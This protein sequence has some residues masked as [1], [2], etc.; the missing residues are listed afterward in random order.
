M[1]KSFW[2]VIGSIFASFANRIFFGAGCHLCRHVVLVVV[3]ITITSV[4]AVVV[5]GVQLIGIVPKLLLELFLSET[6]KAP[7][8]NFFGKIL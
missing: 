4:I 7:K 3:A 8:L 5:A 1:A 6:K 2:I